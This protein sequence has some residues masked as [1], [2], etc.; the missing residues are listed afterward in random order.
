MPIIKN[1]QYADFIIPG[2]FL[3]RKTDLVL[4]N[5]YYRIAVSGQ[6]YIRYQS[7]LW[8]ISRLE[9]GKNVATGIT[10]PYWDIP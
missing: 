10:Q 7:K 2:L 6:A 1:G 4:R 3:E 9:H 5:K 8:F